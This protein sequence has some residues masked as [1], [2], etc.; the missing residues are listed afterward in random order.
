MELQRT[1][2]ISGPLSPAYTGQVP[3]NYNQLEGRFK[4]LQGEDDPP[5]R[6]RA[7]RASA[8]LFVPYGTGPS[9]WPKA[10][11]WPRAPRSLLRRLCCSTPEKPPFGIPLALRCPFWL[12]VVRCA[13]PSAHTFS[14]L[15]LSL[16]PNSL[17]LIDLLIC[18]CTR[19]APLGLPAP[20]PLASGKPKGVKCTQLYTQSFRTIAEGEEGV[21]FL[22]LSLE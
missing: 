2:S 22:F 9:A 6:G 15:L 10:C 21:V 19:P 16:H 1:S 12:S 11:G 20:Q 18:R 7:H 17:V 5:S 3:Y 8:A 14:A 4:Q 13:L